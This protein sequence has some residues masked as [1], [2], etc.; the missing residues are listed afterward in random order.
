MESFFLKINLRHEFNLAESE[1]YKVN[2]EVI[3]NTRDR[4]YTKKWEEDKIKVKP[5]AVSREMELQESL[6]GVK[7]SLIRCFETEI[8]L[9]HN[10]CFIFIL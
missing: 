4:E 6:K 8:W 2:Q 10:I 3:K 5:A 9:I 7:V 1:T